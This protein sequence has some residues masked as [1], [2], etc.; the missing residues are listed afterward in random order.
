VSMGYFLGSVL[1]R[2]DSSDGVTKRELFFCF[3]G[4]RERKNVVGMLIA[5]P[6]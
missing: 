2:R 6:D 4:D 1:A 3:I 5:I